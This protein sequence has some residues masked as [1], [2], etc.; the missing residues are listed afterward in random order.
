[1]KFDTNAKHGTLVINYPIEPSKDNWISI[2]L[3]CEDSSIIIEEFSHVIF[4]D[5]VLDVATQYKFSFSEHKE[6][7]AYRK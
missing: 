4:E 6:L 1:M 5:K 2:R 7:V 3:Q